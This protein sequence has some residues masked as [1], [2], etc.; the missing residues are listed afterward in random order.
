MLIC[1]YSE[2]AGFYSLQQSSYKAWWSFWPLAFNTLTFHSLFQ[3]LLSNVSSSLENC[4]WPFSPRQGLRIFPINSYVGHSVLCAH[5]VSWP[6]FYSNWLSYLKGWVWTPF[7]FLKSFGFVVEVSWKMI[8]CRNCK[9][10]E[11]SKPRSFL[12]LVN[13][14]FLSAFLVWGLLCCLP[15]V[16]KIQ[17]H[18]WVKYLCS[19]TMLRD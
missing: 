18:F 11:F 9:S 4:L 12:K 7:F 13:L 15:L 16:S 19:P 5:G 1:L 3:T 17:F 14:L 8:H 2:K 6:G 10:D